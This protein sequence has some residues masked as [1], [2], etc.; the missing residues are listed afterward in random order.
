MG[1]ARASTSQSL[2][3]ENLVSIPCFGL[4]WPI[5][6]AASLRPP[7]HGRPNRAHR[8]D[9]QS[10]QLQ[11]ST[12][13]SQTNHIAPAPGATENEYSPSS[14]QSRPWVSLVPATAGGRN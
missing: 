12:L 14:P 13:S 6:R 2:V 4:G 3:A 5:K 11:N 9:T 10:S 8:H 7:T 1:R